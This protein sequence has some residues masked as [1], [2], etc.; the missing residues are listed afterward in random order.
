MK[1]L[2]F[3]LM[4]IFSCTLLTMCAACSETLS[5]AVEDGIDV[6]NDTFIPRDYSIVETGIIDADFQYIYADAAQ[7]SEISP[8]IVIGTVVDIR[9]SDKEARPTILE[10]VEINTILRGGLCEGD[11]ITVEEFGGY[12]RLSTYVEKYG[13]EKIPFNYDDNDQ[14]EYGLIGGAPKPNI[15][16]EYVFFL[17]ESD[18]FPGAY[19]IVGTFMGKYMVNDGTVERFCPSGEMLYT[20]GTQVTGCKKDDTLSKLIEVVEATPFNEALYKTRF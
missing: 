11:V 16:D 19:N 10:D 2:K 20:Y 6:Q 9:Y 18:I 4:F 8:V 14:I 5:L 7:L 1:Q 15:G 3:L 12:I 17:T 13:N